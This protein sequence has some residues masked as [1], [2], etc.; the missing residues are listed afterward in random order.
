MPP[1]STLRR[2][3]RALRRALSVNQ[4][5][6]HAAAVARLLARQPFFHRARRVGGYW[7]NDGE[8][9]P[10]PLLRI[11]RDRH[12]RVFLPVLRSRPDRRLWF[13][14]IRK[15]SRLIPN[16]FGIPEPQL[17]KRRIRPPWALD[18]LLIP[19]VGFDPTFNRLGMGGGFYDR[20]LAYL[21]TRR[22]WRRPRLVGLAHACQRVGALKT[23]PWDVPLD[24][25]V[26]EE[27]VWENGGRRTEDGGRRTK[28]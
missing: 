9:D 26:T 1:R 6:R 2:E 25:V 17:R 11:A 20:T 7:A 12:K 14:E 23:S 19:L 21:R 8:I 15:D 4:Q 18:L 10:A 3:L 27:G 5:R 13:I 22:R 28:W 16:R 24:G